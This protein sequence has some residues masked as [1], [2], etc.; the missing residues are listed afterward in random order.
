MGCYIFG[1]RTGGGLTPIYVGKSSTGFKRE[2]FQHDKL[3]HYNEA[4]VM[5]SGTP[6]MFFVVKDSGPEATIE[7]C[8]D[9]V[10]NYLIQ[11][12]VQR[13]PKLAN[14]KKVEWSISGVFRAGSGHPSA[15]AT[16][17]RQMLGIAHPV[18]PAVQRSP[19]DESPADT[20][21][22]EQ[23]PTALATALPYGAIS[24]EADKEQIVKTTT[25]ASELAGPGQNQAAAPN[26][27]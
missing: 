12:A 13:N 1:L 23:A 24:I 21:T 2:C 17:F 9:Q 8:L 15:S 5:H 14:V 3:T 19:D 20:E 26:W 16:A 6:V 11:L 4:L 27:K 7:T 10:E 18:Q 25:P 22:E